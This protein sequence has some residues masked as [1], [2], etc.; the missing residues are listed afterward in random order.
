MEKW[1]FLNDTS[2]SILVYPRN[3]MG[4]MVVA[5]VTLPC[6]MLFPNDF[7]LFIYVF[8]FIT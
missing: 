3:S 8:I 6:L 7:I 1:V 5:I 4:K 2:I